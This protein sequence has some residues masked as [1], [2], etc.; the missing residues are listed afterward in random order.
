MGQYRDT[1][2]DGLTID[3]SGSYEFSDG[4]KSIADA[5]ELMRAMAER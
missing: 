2:N 5:G 4:A 1:E 3:S